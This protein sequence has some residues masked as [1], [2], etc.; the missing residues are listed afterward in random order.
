MS[1]CTPK[2]PFVDL[3]PAFEEPPDLVSAPSILHS[4]VLCG[5]VRPNQPHVMVRRQ[6]NAQIHG[7]PQAEPSPQGPLPRQRANAIVHILRCFILSS[8]FLPCVQVFAATYFGVGE[9]CCSRNRGGGPPIVYGSL[10]VSMCQKTVVSRHITATRAIFEPR[11]R[12]ILRY[13]LR[14][15]GSRFRMCTTSCPKMKRAVL[16]P[17]LVMLPNR[18]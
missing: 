11:L 15:L 18:S 13:Q 2:H 16:L 5:V 6:T 1:D 10:Y 9:A 4:T 12:L 3:A 7:P 17:C 14:I 8:A